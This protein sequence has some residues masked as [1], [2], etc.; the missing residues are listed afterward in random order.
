MSKKEIY[1][2]HP[3]TFLKEI[4][5]ELGISQYRLAVETHLPHC[6]VSGIIHGKQNITVTT[7]MKLAKFFN[8]TPGYWLNL[9][10]HFDLYKAESELREELASIHPFSASPPASPLLA[11]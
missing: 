8:Q 10:R 5:D 6:R 2:P 11:A 7:A 1:T 3:G 4:I 9:Q